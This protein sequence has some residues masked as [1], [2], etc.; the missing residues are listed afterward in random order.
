MKSFLVTGSE[1]F[2][3]KHLITELKKNKCN[4]IRFGSPD[5]KDVTK[6]DDVKAIPKADV[7]FHLAARTFIPFSLKNPRETYE[8]NALGTLN[9]LEYCRE[10]RAKLV[11]PSSYVYGSPEY[12]PIDEQHPLK[13]NNPYTRSK[14][15]GEQFCKIYFDD[16]GVQCTILRPFNVYGPGQ[17]GDFLMPSIVKQ[18]KENGK[19]RLKDP[20]PKRDFIY[21]K[22]AALAL[23]KAADHKGF[24]IF[25]IG[26]GKSY[27]VRQVV[28]K[29]SDIHGKK[30]SIKYTNEKRRNEIID[31][32]ADISKAKKE[33]GWHPTIGIDEGLKNVYR[34][35]KK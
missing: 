23:I 16:Y 6:W 26:C 24:G 8:V 27:S 31:C 9:I 32:Y 4:V 18:L 34:L 15:L 22:D 5:S 13:A 2:I 11:Y 25:N 29:L 28:E 7:V 33:L 30:I 12:L 19:I 35:Y 21:V 1:G 20:N 3:G 10:K 17:R 14:I